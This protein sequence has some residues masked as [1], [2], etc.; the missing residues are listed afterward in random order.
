MGSK[1]ES[2]WTNKVVKVDSEKKAESNVIMERLG[3]KVA[4]FGPS[5]YPV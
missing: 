2:Q 1:P 3:L 4:R 5:K